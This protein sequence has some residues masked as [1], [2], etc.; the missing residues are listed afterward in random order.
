VKPTLALALATAACAL[1]ACVIPPSQSSFGGAAT[2]GGAGYRA[3]VG[4]HASAADRGDAWPVDLG[5]G[6]V[7]EGG[8]DRDAVHGTYVSLGR[9]IPLGGDDALW[10]AGRAEMFWMTDPGE[11][12]DGVVARLSYRRHLTGVSWGSGHGGGSGALGVFGALAAGLYADVGARRFD[13]GGGEVF[14]SAGVQLDL[15][16]LA[17]ITKLWP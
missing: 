1:G 3:S 15:P 4:A 2:G 7:T 16:L 5:A 11:P 13:G 6:W 8:G 9:R 14:A 12:R 17:A 10:L